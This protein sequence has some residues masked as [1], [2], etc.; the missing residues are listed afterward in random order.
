[1]HAVLFSF[2]QA[3]LAQYL[4]VMGSIGHRLAGLPGERI[5]GA[6]TLAKDIQQFQPG[7]AAQGLANLCEEFVEPVFVAST[8]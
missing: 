8:G 3:S 2:N 1:M 6:G 5:N 7:S 4:Q